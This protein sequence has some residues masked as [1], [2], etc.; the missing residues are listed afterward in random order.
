MKVDRRIA[1]AATFLMAA[2]LTQCKTSTTAP[3]NG[4]TYSVTSPAVTVPA[5]PTAPVTVAT[6]DPQSAVQATLSVSTLQAI[7]ASVGG[8]ATVT[9]TDFDPSELSAS[10]RALIGPNPA[11]IIQFNITKSGSAA[12]VALDPARAASIAAQVT[13]SGTS[14]SFNITLS[15][16]ATCGTQPALYVLSSAGTSF[17]LVDNTSFTFNAGPP[18]T[19]SGTTTQLQVNQLTS[20]MNFYCQGVGVVVSGGNGGD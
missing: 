7:V 9:M 15:N 13:G 12:A 17:S 18:T 8:A 16:G 20:L 5:T 19:I 10:V 2:S 3:Y 6:S 11:K 1:I 14:V 4:R